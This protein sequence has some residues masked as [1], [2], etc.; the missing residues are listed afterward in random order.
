MPR[1]RR[2]P[3]AVA[4]A[5]LEVDIATKAQHLSDRSR[6]EMLDD[7][8][9]LVNTSAEYVVLF[10]TEN[11]VASKIRVERLRDKLMPDKNGKAPFSLEP[12]DPSWQ[13]VADDLT[14]VPLKVNPK[15]LKCYLHPEADREVLDAVGLDDK[16]CQK[17]NIPTPFMLRLHMQ[18][19]H[20]TEWETIREH[21]E[22]MKRKEDRDQQMELLRALTVAKALG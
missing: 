15:G 2:I 8:Q 21:Q 5:Q 4:A 12:I 20:K 1:P 19:K 9:S 6:P 14:G 18:R 17:S 3:A 7:I 10:S 16:A 13:Y 22:D 11:G